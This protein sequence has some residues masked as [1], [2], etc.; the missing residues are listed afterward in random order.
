MQ[1]KYAFHLIEPKWQKRW[2]EDGLYNVDRRGN[3]P[4]LYCLE[5]FPYPSGDLHMGHVRNYSLGD[6]VARYYRMRGYDVLHPIGWDAF[7]L[8]A[9]NAAI[10]RGIHP[11]DW[12][13]QNIANMRQQMHR[14]GFSYDWRRE[15]ATCRPDYYKWTEWMFLLL[16]KRG[17]AYK[18]A[19]KVNWC[20]SC[21]TVLANE[22][23]VNG[24]CWRCHTPVEQRQLEQWFFRI[25]AYAEQ[26]LEDLRMLTD[27]P[28]RVKVMQANWIGKSE[29]AEVTFTVEGTGQE[30][31]VFTTRPD[32]LFGVTY[33]V[34]A[35]E[36]PLVEE[37]AAGKPEAVAV[38]RLAAEAARVAARQRTE[39][40]KI[41][42]PTGAWAIN[43]VNGERVPIWV[44]NYVV[45]EYGTGA[46]MGVP[47]HDQRDFEFARKFGLPVR[48]VIQPQD[49]PVPEEGEDLEAAYEGPGTL[50]NSGSFDGLPWEEGKKRITAWL[51]EHGAGKPQ[52]QYRLRDW[53][54]SRQR[55]WGAP[56]PLIYCDHCGTVPVSE[57]DLPVLLPRNVDFRPGGPSPLARCPEFV[58]TTCPRCGRP[59]R[60]ETDTMDTFMCSSWY[61]L[62]YASPHDDQAPFQPADV[63]YWLP[64]DQYIGGIEHAVMHLLYSR[65]LTKVLYDAGLVKFREPFQRLFTQGMVTLGGSA[66]S[67]SK[68]NIVDPNDIVAKYGA[69]TARVFTLFAAPPERDLEW[70]E[71]GVEGAYRFLNRVW[72]LA[73][74]LEPLV[75]QPRGGR[76]QGGND[77]SAWPK[78]DRELRRLLHATVKKVG[79]DIGERFMHNTA[80]SSIM[81]L[82]N[83]LYDYRQNVP[84]ERQNAVLLREALQK[85]LLI[86]APFAPYITEEIWHQLGWEGSIHLQP[87]P[88]WD[89]AALA[90]EEVTVVV[91]VNGKVRDRLVLPADTPEEVL[92]QKALQLP[93]IQPFLAGRTVDKVVSVPGRLVNIVV[94]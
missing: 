60:R 32:T 74:E 8:P 11:A 53:L 19:A 12:T 58:N 49:G 85:L 56:I 22:Q 66:M 27:W 13:E 80:I 73:Y 20:P 89:E 25:T 3:R 47:A 67:K 71:Q 63:D 30:I 21:A 86:L 17:L 38:R 54:I 34:L 50:V 69:D 88:Q 59:A 6:S 36:N 62:R 5:M 14:L 64:V 87:W 57:N 51:Q 70:S 68:G 35:P 26:L 39:Q 84:P 55:Y 4:K 29:G 81:E 42:V 9:E 2:E 43:P 40:E 79:Q 52:V 45:M 46:V 24:A 41:G 16:Y 72:R 18:A 77:P 33:L 65:F 91:Q 48:V 28:E 93:K 31:T 78:E 94:H 23:V 1:E 37:L 76:A 90:A 44:A 15:V 10:K 83:A 92:R 82:V 7:G 61:Y 75:R